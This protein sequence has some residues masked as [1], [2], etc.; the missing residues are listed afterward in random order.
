MF[1]HFPIYDFCI[2]VS[3]AKNKLTIASLVGHELAHMWFG[4]LV[5]EET[6]TFKIGTYFKLTN[7][8]NSLLV[9]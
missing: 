3:S 9:D 1:H 5:S 8:G 6:I 7:Q 2:G 4:N